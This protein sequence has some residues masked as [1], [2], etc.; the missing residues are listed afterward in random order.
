M[1]DLDKSLQNLIDA[2]QFQR[3]TVPGAFVWIVIREDNK[4]SIQCGSP[5]L[6]IKARNCLNNRSHHIW[7]VDERVV[8]KTEKEMDNVLELMRLAKLL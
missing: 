7:R 3:D 5:D 2:L 8:V 4:I 1:K 6:A